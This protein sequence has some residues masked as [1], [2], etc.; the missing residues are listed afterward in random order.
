MSDRSEAGL[1]RQLLSMSAGAAL[2][3]LVAGLLVGWLLGAQRSTGVAGLWPLLALALLALV[4]LAGLNR[5][6]AQ[7][8]D[9]L[10]QLVAHCRTLTQRAGVRFEQAV[11]SREEHELATA[12]NEASDA[13]AQ[14]VADI[15]AVKARLQT[16]LS[17]VPDAMLGLDEHLNI[18][19]AN[20]AVASVFGIET[21]DAIGH[22]LVQLLP[23]CSAD[24]A[25]EQLGAAAVMSGSGVRVARAET[26]GVR[27]GSTSFPVELS[28][29][30]APE[31]AASS[32]LRY[33]VVVR[34]QTEKRWADDQLRLYQRAL[35]AT[36]NGVVIADMSWP[37]APLVYA[38][39]AFAQL[40]GWSRDEI[41]GMNCRVLQ[42]PDRDQPGIAVL[43][44]AIAAG[45]PAEATLRN[46]RKDGTPFFNELALAPVHDAQDKLTHYVGIINDVT[47]REAARRALADRSARLDTIFRLSPDGFVLFDG[48]G[49]LAYCNP[50]FAEMT[51][52][53]ADSVIG[54]MNLASFDANFAQQCDPAQP[55]EPIA[56]VLDAAPDGAQAA[57]AEATM[58]LVR[59]VRR[60][61]RRAMRRT[62]T[63]TGE[64]IL[65][66]RDV[67]RETEVDRMKSEFLTTAAHE[68]RTPMASIF[69]FSE[70]L[71]RRPVPDDRRRDMVETI[72][73]Q[74]A[75]LIQ[76]LNELLDLA[77]IEARQGKDMKP[78][79]MRVAELIDSTLG[80]LMVPGDTRQVA[81]HV[82]HGDASIHVDSEKTRQALLNVLSNA[83]KYS[84]QGG[85]IEVSVLKG[86]RLGRPAVGIQVRDQGIG[87][88]PAQLQRV[89]ERFYRADPS[90]N[91]PGTGLGMSLVKEIVELQGGEVQI[92]S[93]LGAGT[94]VTLWLPLATEM[95]VGGHELVAA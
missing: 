63:E 45:Q 83:Y 94:R 12:I 18:V 51:G 54:M 20:P 91:I 4:I 36:A 50:S 52:W 76:M 32:G 46:Y 28:I 86:E 53:Q 81:L 30:E 60:T 33:T 66:F 72:H 40:T 6:L 92:D 85:A 1:R 89:C 93:E 49:W 58:A 48:D 15:Q 26:E 61:L 42:G 35:E 70:L 10:Q 77:R 79:A 82:E 84:P 2:L 80:S 55:Y 9:P 24:W 44:K 95:L 21:R 29:S 34:D 68:L 37:G 11:G 59:P 31:V 56:A 5:R 69:G 78:A 22:G 38:N 73:R 57:E 25:R 65:F 47:Q 8:L 41:V 67:T 43:R 19:V 87:M 62:M 16:L 88:T 14:Q 90:G 13:L 75:W 39:P 17:A 64:T 74:A 7:R 27:G 3:C 71:L 23:A